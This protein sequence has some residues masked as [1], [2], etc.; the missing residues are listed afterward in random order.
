[1]TKCPSEISH[2]LSNQASSHITQK[3]NRDISCRKSVGKNLKGHP[4]NSGV[5]GHPEN[6]G[7]RGHPENKENS[8]VKNRSK[9]EERKSC[10]K[11][12]ESSEK[13]RMQAHK[14]SKTIALAE[15]VMMEKNR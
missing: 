2:L 12:P 8:G 3:S 14:S 1:M 10:E 6:S 15:K 5:R 9:K 4:E 11:R 13:W 7:V